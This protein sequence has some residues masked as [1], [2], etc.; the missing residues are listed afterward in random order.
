MKK[1]QTKK[2]TL[3]TLKDYIKYV[4]SN[5]KKK[6]QSGWTHSVYYK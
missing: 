4:Q 2:E 6:Q 5:D 1:E 3:P